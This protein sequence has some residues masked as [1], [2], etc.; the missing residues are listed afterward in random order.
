VYTESDNSP[1]APFPT[2]QQQADDPGTGPAHPNC[3]LPA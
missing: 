2:E 1:P 3:S